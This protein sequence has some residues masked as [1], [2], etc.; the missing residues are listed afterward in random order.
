M[1]VGS[2][3]GLRHALRWHSAILMN[4]MILIVWLL[5]PDY[6]FRPLAPVS[7]GV[8]CCALITDLAN[9]VLGGPVFS[10]SLDNTVARHRRRG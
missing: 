4:K 10:L 5:R 2:S 3:H 1:C 8:H 9:L 6:V 7:V